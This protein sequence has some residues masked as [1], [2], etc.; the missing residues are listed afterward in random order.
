MSRMRVFATIALLVASAVLTAVSVVAL[1]FYGD[2]PGSPALPLLT[3][4][5][6]LLFAAAVWCLFGVRGRA[7]IVLLFVG[8][9]MIGAAALAGPPNTSTDSARYAWDGIVQN[10]GI[11]PYDYVPADPAVRDLRQEWLFP[12][13]VLDDRGEAVCPGT[14]IMKFEELDTGEV[15]CSAINRLPVPTIYPPLAELTFAGVRALVPATAEFWPMQVFGLVGVLAVTVLLVALLRRRG[16]D[17]R[18]AALWGW[19]PLVATEAITNSHIDILGA[20]LLVVAT[21][22]VASG[23]PWRGGIALGAAIGAKLI[24]V[25]G[26]PA[27][28]RGR[29]VPVIVAAVVTFAVLYV[30]YVIASGIE[31]ISYLPGYLTEEG[32]GSGDRFVLLSPYL[33]GLSALVVAGI[34][35]LVVG[36]L[37]WRLSDPA[38]P[39]L[40]QLVMI[41]A[42]LA[43]VSPRYP[44]YALLLVPMVVMTRRWEWLAIPAALTVRLLVHGA[45]PVRLAMVIAIVIVMIG[46]VKRAEPA[47]RD[48]WK[49]LVRSPISTLFPRRSEVTQR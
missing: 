39:W 17:Q 22:L 44:W 24:P 13:P 18:W 29:P 33:P 36:V 8:T 1:P 6:W 26:A 37:V 21:A 14:K 47:T 9:A 48:L 38:D 35:L 41:G 10:A 30:P 19:C 40:G 46:T 5:L 15:V 43:I 28:L 32:Y 23:R 20:L 12:E 34:L 45:Q 11:S 7:A 25:I 49:S 4:T 16:L 42:T 2:D 27:L 3:V 31:V